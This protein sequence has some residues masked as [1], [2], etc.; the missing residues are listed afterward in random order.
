MKVNWNIANDT[1]VQ[2]GGK[3]TNYGYSLA[4]QQV[5]ANTADNY[6]TGWRRVGNT[7]EFKSTDGLSTP[8]WYRWKYK[9]PIDGIDC[10]G[11]DTHCELLQSLKCDTEHTFACEI[12][13]YIYIFHMSTSRTVIYMFWLLSDGIITRY[14]VLH[15]N[16][17]NLFFIFV[18][19]LNDINF[20]SYYKLAN[21]KFVINK[22][23]FF[24]FFLLFVF[25]L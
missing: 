3:L 9:N 25:L 18:S 13:E 10:V 4:R 11:H 1:C 14:A 2:Q 19:S 24:L 5:Y 17:S 21:I 7:S 6:W 8:I 20:Y 12:G 23:V 15:F 22:L 16:I